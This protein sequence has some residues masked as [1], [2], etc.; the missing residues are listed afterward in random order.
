MGDQVN[1]RQFVMG[2]AAAGIAAAVNGRGAAASAA[3]HTGRSKPVVVASYNGLTMKNGGEKSC[4]ELAF[5]RIVRGDDVLEALIEGVNIVELDPEDASVGYGGRPN[6]DG[7]VQLDA[8]CMHG[9]KKRAGGVASLEGVRTPS[10]VARAVME[11]TDHHLLVGRGAQ[12]FARSMGFEIEDD[13]NTEKSRQMWLEWKRRVDPE[14]YLDPAQRSEAAHRAGQQMIREGL[15]AES[16]YYGTINCNGVSPDGDVCGVTTTSGLAWKMAG[17]VGDSPILGAGLY[18]DNDHGAA[19]STGRGEAN[20]YGL[21]SFLVVEELRR[22]SSPKDAGME[23]LRRIRANTI[24]RRLLNDRGLPNFNVN[25]YVVNKAGEH[26]GV[27][28]YADND[29]ARYAV[30]TENGPELARVEPLLDGNSYA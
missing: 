17:R 11:Y 7:V 1:R 16:E 5:E 18:V 13:L 30:C 12:A 10:R 26:A 27:A 15:M 24:E 3:V 23:A 25:F 9:P 8:C 19:G 14:H 6:A 20:L 4:V 28:L 22:G 21:C 29:E 2:G